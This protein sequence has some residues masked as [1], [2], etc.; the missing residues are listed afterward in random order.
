MWRPLR[1]RSQGGK[2]LFQFVDRLALRKDHLL[3][4]LTFTLKLGKLAL[5][6]VLRGMTLTGAFRQA[7]KFFLASV[8]GLPRLPQFVE[9]GS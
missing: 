6:F 5:S 9:D 4:L 8:N 1:D 7:G 3:M 2:L